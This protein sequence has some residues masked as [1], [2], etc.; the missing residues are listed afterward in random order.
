[1][2]RI[3]IHRFVAIAV[4]VLICNSNLALATSPPKKGGVLPEINLPAPG[5][6]L[7]RS[8]LGLSGEGLFQIP[9]I[10]AKAVIIQ[11]FSMY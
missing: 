10:K 7:H 8:Y 3:S 2:K 9:Q 1:M 5:N 11:I 6:P 4:F